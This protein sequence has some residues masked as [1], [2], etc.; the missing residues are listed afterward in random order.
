LTPVTTLLIAVNIGAFA[1]LWYTGGLSSNSSLVAHGALFPL[2]VREYGQWWRIVS[3]AFLHGGFMHIAMNML[4]LAQLGA[5]MEN[6]IGSFPMLWIYGVSLIG[7]GLSIV[8][9][10]GNQVTVG[11][12]GAIYGLFGGMLAIG[13]RYGQRGRP[14]VASTLPVLVINLVLT[15]TIPNISISG[16]IGGLICG[17]IA[18]MGLSIDRRIYTPSPPA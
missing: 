3:G 12:S 11:A 14:L 8:A 16:H 5:L 2:Y 6:L 18:T 1:W 15:Y 17:F 7:S 13:L 9:F 4:A 10:S